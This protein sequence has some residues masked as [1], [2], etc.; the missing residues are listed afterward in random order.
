[1]EL[2]AIA[3]NNGFVFG[4]EVKL[5]EG[6]RYKIIVEEEERKIDKDLLNL[7]GIIKNEKVDDLKEYLSK[8]KKLDY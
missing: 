3:H 2:V 1:M 5:E 4:P 6:K 8:N 7:V